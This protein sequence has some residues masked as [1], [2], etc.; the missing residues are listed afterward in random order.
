MIQAAQ[1]QSIDPKALKGVEGANPN[2]LLELEGSLE[3]QDF[4]NEL[5]ASL[6]LDVQV[7]P[8]E[9]SAEQVLELPTNLIKSEEKADSSS[10]KVF[11]PSLTKDVEK[12]IR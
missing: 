8:V 1:I 11:D 10:P 4:A 9:V 2:E 12:L 6:A 3:A 7:A 5:E